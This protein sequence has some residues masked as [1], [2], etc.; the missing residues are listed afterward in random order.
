L[1]KEKK[2][3]WKVLFYL[4]LGVFAAIALNNTIAG[5]ANPLL[6]SLK[7]SVSLNG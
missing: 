1:E 3:N 7:L 2:M 5:F 6:S 4:G